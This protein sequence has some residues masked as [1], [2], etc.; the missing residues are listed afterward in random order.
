M[1]SVRLIDLLGEVDI[2]ATSGVVGEEVVSGVTQHSAKVEPGWLFCCRPGSREDGHDHGAD[3]VARGASALIVERPLRLPVNQVVVRDVGRVLGPVAAAFWGH[4]SRHLTVVGVTGT[5]G[6]TTTTYLV[7]AILEQHGWPT[8]IVGTLS[9]PL[10]TPEPI[11]L[12]R[13]LAG[14]VTSGHRAVA[15][16]VSSHGLAQHRVDSTSF[17]VGIFTNLDRDHLDY[18]GDM[19]TYFSAKAELFDPTRTEVGVVNADDSWGARLLASQRIPLVAYSLGDN[20]DL[21]LGATA[22]TF[23]WGGEGFRIGLPGQFNVSNALAAATAT[24]MLG[25]P[26]STIAAAL[27]TVSG[28][29]GRMEHIDAG[30]AYRVVVDCA[31]TP[32][33]LRQVLETLSGTTNGRLLVVFGCG[34]DR[35]RSKRPEMGGLVARYADVG[36]LTTDNPRSESAERI[37]SEVLAGPGTSRLI[38]KPDR[39]MAIASAL[40]DAKPADTVLIAGKGDQTVQQVGPLAIPF[41]DRTVVREEI[42]L[43]SLSGLFVSGD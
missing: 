12:Q 2:V 27:S 8:G 17:T 38:L 4:P 21:V 40:A 5:N 24:R 43:H 29:P 26:A 33:A 28:P 1:K 14:F 41:D 18:H 23:R 6:K 7:R 9:G 3:A 19:E 13:L 39:R 16:E 30:Q 10:T 25:V 36:L 37:F 34:G 35:D 20:S 32:S 22:S 42:Q 31:H 11:D 15:M